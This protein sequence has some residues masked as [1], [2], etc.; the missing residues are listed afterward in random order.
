M[1]KSLS[2][3]FISL[4]LICSCLIPFEKSFA[5]ANPATMFDDVEDDL[6]VGGDIFNNFNEDLEASQVV[7]DE[8]FY[9]YGRFFSFNVGIGITRFEGN[10]GRAYR[11]NFDPSFNISVNYFFDFL[12]SFSL[13]FQYSRHAMFVDT[14][15]AGSRTDPF[16]TVEVTMLR[17]FFAFRYYM[18]TTHYGNAITYSNPYALLRLEYWYQSVKFPEN[19]NQDD[20]SGG[21]IGIGL[22]FG[23]EFP[24][25]IKESYVGVEFLWHNAAFF[26]KYTKDYSAINTSDTSVA[27]YEDL[28]GNAYSIFVTY[29][30]TW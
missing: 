3:L 16:G 17:P 13:G 5:Q 24:V 11:Q 22:G 8:R 12:S 23:L 20:D 10:R 27:T 19:A 7:E 15:T 28:T 6:N 1:N 4:A 18:D 30:I 2:I 26:D 9:R 14:V 25:V 21:G 29:N